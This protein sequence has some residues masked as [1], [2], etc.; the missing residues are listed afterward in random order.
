MEFD[1]RVKRGPVSLYIPSQAGFFKTYF[2]K[3]NSKLYVIHGMGEYVHGRVT[4]CLRR[5]AR[6]KILT[7]ASSSKGWGRGAYGPPPPL[8]GDIIS[9]FLYIFLKK[10]SFI[11]VLFEGYKLV[12]YY[13]LGYVCH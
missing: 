8:A 1:N 2:L 4:S 7:W 11:N 10:K 13:L 3:H 9:V 6:L 5:G 12:E